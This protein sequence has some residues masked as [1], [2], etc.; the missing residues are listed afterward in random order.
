MSHVTLLTGPERRRRWSE[1][2][3]RRILAAAFAPGATVVA[4]ARQYDVATSLIYKWRRAVRA[5][6]TGFAEVVVAPDEPVAVSRPP[7]SPAVIE[8]E[9]AGKVRLRIPLSTP[10]TLAAAMVKA[11]GVS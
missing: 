2:D 9:I 8:L 7:A 3:Q 4:V 11:L 1:A 6:E 10:P 5:R